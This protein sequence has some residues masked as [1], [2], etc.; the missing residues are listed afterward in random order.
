M[1]TTAFH[2]LYSSL[3]FGHFCDH[4]AAYRASS[5][6]DELRQVKIG[7]WLGSVDVFESALL[8]FVLQKSRQGALGPVPHAHGRCILWADI[9]NQLAQGSLPESHL[10]DRITSG[11]GLHLLDSMAPANPTPENIALAHSKLCSFVEL[12]D[13][14]S[15]GEMGSCNLTGERLGIAVKGWLP[16]LFRLTPISSG[17]RERQDV[18][19][20]PP[21]LGMVQLS[22]PAPSGRI[23]LADWF[24]IDQFTAAVKD[25]STAPSINQAFGRIHAT[26]RYAEEFGFMSV[27]VGNTSPC[28][29]ERDGHLAIA[30]LAEKPQAQGHLAG[31]I[32][33]DLWWATA[34]DFDTLVAIVAR[35]AGSSEAIKIVNAHIQERG[36]DVV[37]V[38]VPA[39]STLHLSFHDEDILGALACSEVPIQGLSRLHAVLSTRPLLWEPA[40]HRPKPRR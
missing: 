34:I 7:A 35:S 1:P 14:H 13:F 21:Q 8:A 4:L 2:D 39:G 28:V 16:R 30:E 29:I 32:C 24:R 17:R 37:E 5:K 19:Q 18:D 33:T 25:A 26:R 6:E 31:R 38:R 36:S 10:L 11:A 40:P 22:I 20:D 23:L 9:W 15:M 3:A 12:G 27:S